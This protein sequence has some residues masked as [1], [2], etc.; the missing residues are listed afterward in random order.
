[1]MRQKVEGSDSLDEIARAPSSSKPPDNFISLLEDQMVNQVNVKRVASFSQLRSETICPV[2][3][4]LDL[5][6]RRITADRGASA[7]RDYRPIHL[8]F[9]LSLS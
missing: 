1:M 8:A 6:V 4:S 9:R 2:I 5:D 3:I 7:P